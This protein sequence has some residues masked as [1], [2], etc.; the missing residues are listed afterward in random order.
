MIAL[1]FH[2][3]DYNVQSTITRIQS[4]DFENGGWQTAKSNHHKKKTHAN[5]PSDQSSNNGI[6]SDSERSLSQHTSPTPSLRGGSN[7]DRQGRNPYSSRSNVNRRNPTDSIQSVVEVTASSS[8]VNEEITP[9]ISS[10]ADE[11]EFIGGTSQSLTFDNSQKKT[12]VS[13][14]VSSSS[15]SSVLIK[16]SIPQQAVCMHPTIRFSSKPIDVQFGD[17][18]WN[19]SVPIAI[20][21]SNSPILAKSLD[22]QTLE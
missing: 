13:S 15:S 5:N 17:V 18:Q 22:E 14:S 19:D 2:E 12:S 3:C 9:T 7:R 4:G 11:Y 16:R 10:S 8:N 20:T 21:P 6:A 1:V